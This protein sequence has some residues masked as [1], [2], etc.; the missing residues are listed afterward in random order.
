MAAG[1]H[2]NLYIRNLGPEVDESV[3]NHLFA[4]YGQVESC[5][6]VKN[7][8]THASRGYGFVKYNSVAAAQEAIKYLH[9]SPCGSSI[10]EVKFADAD[11][12]RAGSG[13]HSPLGQATNASLDW[14]DPCFGEWAALVRADLLVIKVLEGRLPG[15]GLKALIACL[16]SRSAA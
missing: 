13:V 15:F 1:P 10:L 3:L 12:G 6:I 7:A 4:P 9:G 8:R 16:C 11:A 2:S 5:R 14:A